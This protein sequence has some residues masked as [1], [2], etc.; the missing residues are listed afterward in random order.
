MN[1]NRRDFLKTT[2]GLAAAAASGCSILNIKSGQKIPIAI[3][4][5]AVRGPFSKDVPGTLK[6]VSQAGFQA[7]E[8]WGY[9]GTPNVF[10]NYSAAQL[11]KMLDDL[12]LKCCGIHLTIKALQDASLS[13]TIDNN[14]VLGNSLLN[15]ASAGREMSSPDNIKKFAAFLNETTDKLQ[16]AKMCVGYHAH[17]SDFAKSTD[18]T[19]YESLFSQVNKNVNMQID[20]GHS[21]TAGADAAAILKRFPGRSQSVHLNET[22]QVPFDSPRYKAIF[23]VIESNGGTKWYILEKEAENTV[24]ASS[25][26][27]AKLRKIGK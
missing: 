17:D 10:Q 22:P 26:G 1:T 9:D 15:I 8:F 18:G 19:I 2:L 6:A 21:I 14:K 7:V 20:V 23:D 5:Y 25:E 13:R 11:K 27:L 12:N 3:Q 24:A 16:S 4:L